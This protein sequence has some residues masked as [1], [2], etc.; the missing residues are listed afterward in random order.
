MYGVVYCTLRCDVTSSTTWWQQKPGRN[1]YQ[2]H[3]VAVIQTLYF[4]YL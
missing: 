3:K 1:P 2:T 4:H